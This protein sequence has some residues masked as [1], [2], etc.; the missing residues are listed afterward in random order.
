MHSERYTKIV[1]G[2]IQTW[3]RRYFL[4]GTYYLND[5]HYLISTTTTKEAR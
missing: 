2:R 5:E 1:D 3:E 4:G